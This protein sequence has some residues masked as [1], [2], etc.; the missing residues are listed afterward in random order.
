MYQMWAVCRSERQYRYFAALPE[1][2][3][4][5]LR[6]AVDGG[7]GPGEVLKSLF[8]GSLAP[9]GLDREWAASKEAWHP[10]AVTLSPADF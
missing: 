1:L 3:R 5:Q 2:R 9:T 10:E 7:E 4:N 8:G 6:Q